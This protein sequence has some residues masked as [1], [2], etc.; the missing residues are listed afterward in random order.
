MR[1]T[2]SIIAAAITLAALGALGAL[3]ARHAGAQSPSPL[4]RGSDPVTLDP[5]DFSANIDNAQWPMT[6]GSRWVYRVTD[7]TDGS[8]MR[9][10]ITVTPR[11]S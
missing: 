4:P 2:K 11:R 7:M 6:V 8:T 1:T 10:V 9:Q 5:A 3:G